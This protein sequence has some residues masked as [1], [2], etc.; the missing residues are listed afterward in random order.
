MQ[1]LLDGLIDHIGVKAEQRAE[2]SRDRRSEMGDVIDL[3]LVQAD[4]AHQVHLDLVAGGQCPQQ[5][6]A[7]TPALLRDSQDWRDVVAGVAVLGR[8]ERVVVI[9]LAHRGA[10][11][12]RGPFRVDADVGTA[13]EHGRASWPRMREGLRTSGDDRRAVERGDRPPPY[14]R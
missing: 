5:V 12:P 7:A 8:E 6:H 4:R 14:Y 9:E 11:G 10:V 1:R 3:V 2:A 13:A